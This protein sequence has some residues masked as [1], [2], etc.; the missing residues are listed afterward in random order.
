LSPLTTRRD[1]GEGILTRLRTGNICRREISMPLSGTE[2][3]HRPGNPLSFY[4]GGRSVRISSE[5]RM[6]RVALRIIPVSALAWIVP[7]L[8]RYCFLSNRFPNLY[9]S[10]LPFDGLQSYILPLLNAYFTLVSCLAYS[11]IMK[12][13][14]ICSSETPVDF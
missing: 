6:S 11:A 12:M 8:C 4:S 3:S 5:N 14:A 10:A 13:E 7:G 2:Y 9:C 1:Y